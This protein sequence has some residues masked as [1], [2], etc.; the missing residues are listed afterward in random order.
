MIIVQKLDPKQLEALNGAMSAPV[1]MIHG[2]PGTG[3]TFLGVLLARSILATTSEQILI[4]CFTNHA[5]DDLLEDFI[6]AGITSI[7]R[8][9][10]RSKNERLA[11]YNLIEKTKNGKAE[12]NREQKRRYAAIMEQIEKAQEDVKRLEK[13][14][15]REIGAKWWRT[16]GPFLQDNHL[17]CWN[18][19]SVEFA[20]ESQDKDGF[21]VVGQ[22]AEDHLWKLWLKGRPPSKLYKDRKEMPLWNMTKAERESQKAIWQQE[23][24]SDEFKEL[25]SALSRID[26]RKSELQELRRMQDTEILSKARI[27]GCTTTKAAMSKSLLD[28]L[29]P[30]VVLVE[31]AAEI[32]E[33]HIIT[34]LSSKTKH[35]IMIGDHKQLRPKA[36]N[37]SLTVEA[38]RGLDFN[39]SMFERL[40]ATIPPFS[41]SVQHRMHPEISAIPRL[42][43]YP[44]LRDAETVNDR[45]ELRGLSTRLAFIN[46]SVMEDKQDSFQDRV[47]S[48]SRTN[49]HEVGLVQG[50]VRYMLQQ[51]Y[52]PGDLVVLT[53]YLGQLL[54]L[55]DALASICNVF[56]D[57]LDVSE[58]RRSGEDVRFKSN[59]VDSDENSPLDPVRVATIDNYQGEEADIVIVSLVRSNPEGNIGF[60]RDAEKLL[61]AI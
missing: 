60:L 31:E 17:P 12:F 13:I 5:L 55:K 58:L 18:Q 59:V 4:V 45:P 1:A 43:T 49:T 3:K 39:K 20:E 54:R 56:V 33:A 61:L 11:E 46:H 34:S 26:R 23:M 14:C 47:E 30:G 22:G 28:H 15:S 7:V 41:L 8:L 38:G 25:A 35:L 21:Q 51:G 16:I 52:K 2:P 37:F 36:Q 6:D 32:M 50:V 42:I 29:S 44:D 10:G 53:P 57:D 19:L 24:Y 40:A 9:G 48:I 27:I